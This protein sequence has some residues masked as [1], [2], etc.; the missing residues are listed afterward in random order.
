MR[1]II[2]TLLPA[3]LGVATSAPR[4][5]GKTKS[6]GLESMLSFTA[7]NIALAFLF[8]FSVIQLFGLL[9]NWILQMPSGELTLALIYV[10][11]ALM[12]ALIHYRMLSSRRRDRNRSKD[13]RAPIAES[14]AK[15]LVEG[16]MGGLQKAKKTEASYTESFGQSP[17]PSPSY[18][19]RP[20]YELRQNQYND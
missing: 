2:L 16:F 9:N 3:L 20:H 11:I 5:N 4:E 19:E 18:P 7:W 14:L 13:S 8:I 12:C 17:L 1:S 10:S 15:N 6:R